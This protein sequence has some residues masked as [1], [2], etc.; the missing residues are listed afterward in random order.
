MD[1]IGQAF[2]P[3]FLILQ[4]HRRHDG[5]RSNQQQK[6]SSDEKIVHATIPFGE[7][8]ALGSHL[9]QTPE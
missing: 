4:G 6:D 3:I 8:L 7:C 9:D 2:G 5:G 1:R